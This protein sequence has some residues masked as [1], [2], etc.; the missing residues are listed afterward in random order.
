MPRVDFEGVT[1]R[2]RFD[3]HGDI[4]NGAVTIKRVVDGEFKVIDVLR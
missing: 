2:I 4:Q 1:G 3:K